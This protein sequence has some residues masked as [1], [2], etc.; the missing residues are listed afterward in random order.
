MPRS[1]HIAAIAIVLSAGTAAADPGHPAPDDEIL[2][3]PPTYKAN[4]VDVEEHLGAR[5][6]LDARFRTVDGA[7]VTLGEV[8]RGE[9]PAILTFN[10]SDC[11]MLCSLQLNGLV[12]ALPGV[13][14]PGP[15]PA[16]STK[17]GDVAFRVGAQ[18]R[19]VTIDLEPNESLDRLA[20]MRDRYL[21]RLPEAQRAAAREGWTFL[22]AEVPGDG[23]AIRRVAEAVGFHYVYVTE[24][25]EW[26]HPAA[27]IF[28]SA[29]GVVT[30]YV[31]GIEFA[32]AMMRD[33]IFKAG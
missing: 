30:R 23:A 14:E 5:V 11:P 24:R 19:I 20:K 8:L 13:A 9:L 2:P 31:H 26:A 21:A 33:S 16:G 18:F 12:A 6:P 4:S 29:A 25:A 1:A 27:L 10:Y 15:P 7:V 32:P 22:A 17:P 28:L 3:P